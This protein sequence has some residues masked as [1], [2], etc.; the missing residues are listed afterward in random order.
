MKHGT[1]VWIKKTTVPIVKKSIHLKLHKGVAKHIIITCK[2]QFLALNVRPENHAHLITSI[3]AC[4]LD[5]VFHS[6]SLSFFIVQQ[7]KLIEHD[8]KDLL[9]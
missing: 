5:L 4:I 3:L 1:W 8:K 9:M 7:D 6:A 2:H